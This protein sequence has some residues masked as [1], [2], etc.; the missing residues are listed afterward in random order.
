MATTVAIPRF[1]EIVAPCFEVAKYF[2]VTRFADDGR[3]SRETIQ[4]SGCE[5]FGRVALLRDNRVDVLICG[6]IKGFYRDMLTT[7]GVKVIANAGGTVDEI[8]A[9]YSKGEFGAAGGE[10]PVCA[11]HSIPREDLLCWAKELFTSHGYTVFP[12]E[13]KA[14]F[15][16]DLVAEIK[17]PVCQKP[18]RVAVCCGAQT[19]RCD[20]EIIELHNAA[21]IDFHSRVYVHPATDQIREYCREFNIEL[22]DPNAKYA[23]S[24]HP[25]SD[26]IPILQG[27]VTGHEAASGEVGGQP[28]DKNEKMQ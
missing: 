25:V 18:M 4:C 10:K 6:G 2:V 28:Q 9:A 7:A 1:Q 20:Q 14:S 16:I 15:P 23:A 22:I 17:C 3:I 21:R 8:L 24:D 11:E 26:R 27:P 19:Y 13:E 5:G 12:G